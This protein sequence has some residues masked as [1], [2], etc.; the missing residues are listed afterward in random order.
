MGAAMTMLATQVGILN[1]IRNGVPIT[2]MKVPFPLGGSGLLAQPASA[3]ARIA[4]TVLLRAK[5]S[6]LLPLNR[7]SPGG[8]C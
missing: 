8:M 6:T 7:H 4:A 2:L 3:K 1:A 5:L